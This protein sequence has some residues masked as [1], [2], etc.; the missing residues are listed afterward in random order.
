MGSTSLQPPSNFDKV[1]VH[2]L[3]L[4]EAY[5]KYVTLKQ[6]GGLLEGNND[7][8]ENELLQRLSFLIGNIDVNNLDVDTAL[9]LSLTC[10]VA[11]LAHL[12]VLP[13]FLS[14]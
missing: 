8:Y 12:Q 7:Q 6:F 1:P 13:L 11:I 4:Q 9:F 3:S 10:L 14:Q 5:D 2:T